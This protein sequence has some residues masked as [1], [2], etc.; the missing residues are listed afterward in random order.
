MSLYLWLFKIGFKSILKENRGDR[1]KEWNRKWKDQITT[2]V[3][4]FKILRLAS[5]WKYIE[6][7]WQRYLNNVRFVINLFYMFSLET[8]IVKILKDKKKL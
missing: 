3:V 1:L 8:K 7:G 5:S 6:I 4:E 2:K